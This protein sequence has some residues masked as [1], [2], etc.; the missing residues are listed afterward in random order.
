MRFNSRSF[1]EPNKT[2]KGLSVITVTFYCGPQRA[3]E[4]TNGYQ[5]IR[6][7]EK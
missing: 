4:T 7:F 6:V 1:L 5:G 3:M 2:L